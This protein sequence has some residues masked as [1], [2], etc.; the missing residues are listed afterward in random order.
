MSDIAAAAYV[1]AR[2]NHRVFDGP[3]FHPRAFSN[4]YAHAYAAADRGAAADLNAITQQVS[5][6]LKERV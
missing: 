6:S 5:R 1:C 3:A 2:Q 4:L